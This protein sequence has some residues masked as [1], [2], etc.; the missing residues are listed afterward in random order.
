MTNA[1]RR[2]YYA[3]LLLCQDCAKRRGLDLEVAAAHARHCW[4][5]GMV[6]FRATPQPGIKREQKP[7]PPKSQRTKRW[8]FWKYLIVKS[9]R[10]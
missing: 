3:P 4:E 6:P 9:P 8:R 7:A 5:T 10:C 2:D 1:G